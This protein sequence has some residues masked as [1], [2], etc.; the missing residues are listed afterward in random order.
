MSLRLF[1]GRLWWRAQ[2]C[3]A[4]FVD[5]P[6]RLF[7][8]ENGNA[9]GA[10]VAPGGRLVTKPDMAA[11]DNVRV[12]TLGFHPSFQGTSAAAPHAAACAALIKSFNPSLGMAQIRGLL[13]RSALD[14]EQPGLDRDSGAGIVMPL[15]ALQLLQ[16]EDQTRPVVTITT[17]TYNQA[18]SRLTRIAGTAQD[19][20]SG[21]E[22][23]E[24][25]L[26]RD[27]DNRYWSGRTWGSSPIDLRPI[28]TG[29]TFSLSENL[30]ND[31]NL[32][33]GNYLIYVAAVDRAGNRIVVSSR[34]RVTDTVS[35][36]LT[37]KLSTAIAVADEFCA[38]AA[39]SW[40]NLAVVAP[41]VSC[42][43]CAAPVM[44]VTGTALPGSQRKRR[45]RLNCLAAPTRVP[46]NAPL[47]GRLR[48]QPPPAR[49]FMSPQL[50][51]MWP[52]TA[53]APPNR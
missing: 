19:S 51:M 17:P 13:V 47:A 2:S 33:A 4:I 50:A 34:V 14:I 15:R 30:P 20:G 44:A 18:I 6:R 7:F 3:G 23:L 31:L 40:M 35:P 21:L 53:P 1:P 10:L 39:P 16:R 8:D 32:L 29:S 48:H 52:A 45:W 49:S 42:C 27:R 25:F 43:S 12:A 11:A 24:L 38:Y 22:R 36:A 46:G 26:Q 37:M 9:L 41:T 5:G 28:V